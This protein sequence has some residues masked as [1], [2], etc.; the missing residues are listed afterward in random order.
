M[1]ES[2][3]SKHENLRFL[4][5]HTLSSSVKALGDVQRAVEGAQLV[6]LAT[7]SAVLRRIIKSASG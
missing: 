2:I 3:N 5:G 6:T 4:R 1:V 7:P